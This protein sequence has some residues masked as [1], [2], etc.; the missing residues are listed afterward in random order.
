MLA[1]Y[2]LIQ[3]LHDRIFPRPV[4]VGIAAWTAG[5]TRLRII[6]LDVATNQLQTDVFRRAFDLPPDTEPMLLEWIRWFQDV[7]GQRG[8]FDEIGVPLLEH[9]GSKD[10]PFVASQAGEA[11]IESRELDK[12]ADDL[13]RRAVLTLPQIRHAQL[14]HAALICLASAG[15]TR[16]T[17]S[18]IEDAEIELP[19]TLAGRGLLNLSWFFDQ[20]KEK[21]GFRIVDFEAIESTV[22]QQVADALNTFEVARS[23]ELL[24]RDRCFVLHGPGLSD[25]PLYGELLGDATTL[26]EV[27]SPD[28]PNRL[29][30][31]LSI[32]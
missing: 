13:F 21:A 5:E 2:R 24:R 25:Y 15:L 16:N 4:T 26:I 12:F 31:A 17:G 22:G 11:D 8:R 20:E 28:A 18:L 32:A 7:V 19:K 6:G 30:A 9:L 3:Y 1:S 14:E 10:F 29:L 23:R 27:S